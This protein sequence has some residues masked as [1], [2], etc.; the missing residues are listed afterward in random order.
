MKTKKKQSKK[1]PEKGW[2]R[3]GKL[4]Q[5]GGQLVAKEIS[6][7]VK[8]KI[9]QNTL[10]AN[11]LKQ[12]EILVKT[13]GELKGAAMK[14]GQLIS[15]ELSEFL[16]PEV[17]AVLRQLHD[18]STTYP[19]AEMAKIAQSELGPK[20]FGELKDFSEEPLASASIGQ[21][22]TATLHGK[23]VVVKIQYPEI[24]SSI[25]HDMAIVRRLSKAFL[26]INGQSINLEPFFDELR[27][28]LKDEANYRREAKALTAYRELFHGSKFR[29]PQVFPD[30]S[31]EKVITMTCESGERL[32]DWIL[33]KKL[34]GGSV[35]WMIRRVLKLLTEEFFVHGLVQTDP[36]FG[37]FLVDDSNRR[38]ILL[39]CG[40]V[41]SYKSKFREEI[42]DLARLAMMEQREPVVSK[43]ISLDMLSQ[44][45]N[46]EAKEELAQ[47]II[48]IMVLFRSDHQP[49]DFG[50]RDYLADLRQRAFRVV[51][52]L[53][54]SGPARQVIFLNRKLGGMFHLLKEMQAVYD[55][56]PFWQMVEN[57]DFDELI[58]DPAVQLE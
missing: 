10:L 30:Y 26:L 13:L 39:D 52:K 25:D 20:K 9:N 15:I 48:D 16:P 12:A 40:A 4:F 21:V 38:L 2:Q 7:R 14:A 27:A 43:M 58:L 45:E 50:D 1:I 8:S 49:V 36:N 6:L 47:I 46:P 55:I 29:V 23:K 3:A 53:K 37:N 11:R 5:L 35:E 42:R 57:I 54:H 31:T 34:E 44:D 33:R 18:K 17:I 24:S 32:S 28:G 19:G 56:H 22:H 41:R 51:R